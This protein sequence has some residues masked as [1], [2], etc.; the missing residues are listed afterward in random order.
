MKKNNIMDWISFGIGI[1]IVLG[2]LIF[3]NNMKIVLGIIS[4]GAFL[5]GVLFIIQKDRKG[6]I[7]ASGGI[8]LGVSSLMYYL[9]GMSLLDTFTLMISM[10]V[11]LIMV[12]TLIFNIYNKK[13]VKEY[14][15]LSVEAEVVDLITSQNTK[16]PF[17]QPY[18]KY[19]IDG[20]DYSVLYPHF[21]R[22]NVPNIG[23]KVNILVSAKDNADVFFEKSKPEL[24]K[25]MA[26]VLILM[27][28]SFV[29]MILVFV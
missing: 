16:K 26:T 17:Y 6:Y 18:F 11:F 23:E 9:K 15:S 2:V 10:S 13:Q 12:L 5:S 1:T 4:V 27:V 22:S 24:L 20:H 14:Y 8:S 3:Q 7:L 19:Q 29:I 28:I 21:I 25:D